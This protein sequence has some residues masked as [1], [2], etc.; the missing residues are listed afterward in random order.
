MGRIFTYHIFQVT[1]DLQDAAKGAEL[2]L[3]ATIIQQ[4]CQDEQEEA[5]TDALDVRLV[6]VPRIPCLTM[7]RILG[8]HRRD[9]AHVFDSSRQEKQE[10]TTKIS[11]N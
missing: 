8:L 1:G 3:T 9:H 11:T 2:L 5:D 7:F 6:P 10:K 4:Y